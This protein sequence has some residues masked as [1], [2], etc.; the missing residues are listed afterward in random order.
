MPGKC[1][2]ARVAFALVRFTYASFLLAIIHAILQLFLVTFTLLPPFPLSLL[3]FDSVVFRLLMLLVRLSSS[4]Q[5]LC[6]A[7]ALSSGIIY[8]FCLVF[9]ARLGVKR[10]L[11]AVILN[12]L[13]VA[14]FLRS[15][16]LSAL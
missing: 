1:E 11:P 15:F 5:R 6:T 16:L 9:A 13:F 2:R 3:P 7:I 8:I 14:L 4:L 12:I 10:S